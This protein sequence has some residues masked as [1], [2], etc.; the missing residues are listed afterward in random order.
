MYNLLVMYV[1]VKKKTMINKVYNKD[2]LMRKTFPED[3]SKA[4]E[5]LVGL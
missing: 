2:I 5:Y 1:S 3:N 4:A